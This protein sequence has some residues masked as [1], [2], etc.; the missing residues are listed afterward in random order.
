MPVQNPSRGHLYHLL[1]WVNR[2]VCRTL[3][4]LHMPSRSPLPETGPALLVSDHSSYNDPMILTA[5]AGRPLIFLTAREIYESAALNW[6]CKLAFFIPVSRGT[7]DVAA[8]R[9]MLRTLGRGEVIALF[10]EG[11][12]DEYRDE[13]G[14]LGIGYLAIKTG[15]PVVPASIKWDSHRPPTLGRSLLTPGKVSV[16]YGEPIIVPPDT[17]NDRHN[18]SLVTDRIMRAIRELQTQH[19]VPSG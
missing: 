9:S 16:R 1:D 15:A 2:L 5:T 14:H 8:V 7:Q 13:E 17:P 3:Y 6:L 10:P 11:G 18:I 4:Q 19:A 12:I